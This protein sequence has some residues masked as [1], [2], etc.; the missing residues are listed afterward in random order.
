MLVIDVSAKG[1]A[2][3]GS[4]SWTNI[5]LIVKVHIILS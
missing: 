2:H 1:Q 4:M 5:V 3:N